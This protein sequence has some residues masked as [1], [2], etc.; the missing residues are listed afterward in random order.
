MVQLSSNG[1]VCWVKTMDKKI[2]QVL[3]VG[4]NNWS[5]KNALVDKP[6][7]WF[8]TPNENVSVYIN[9]LLKDKDK[10]IDFDVILL[11]ELASLRDY[12]MIFK[13]AKPYAVLIDESQIIED[14]HL[15]ELLDKFKAQKI[16]MVD[17]NKVIYD[18]TKYF[19]VGQY[20]DKLNIEHVQISPSFRGKIQYNGHVNLI[21]MG[22]FGSSLTPILSWQYNIP[23]DAEYNHELWL[24]YEASPNVL[25]ALS[26]KMIQQGSSNILKQWTVEGKELSSPLLIENH[27]KSAYYLAISL[28]VQGQGEIKIGNLHNRL[29]RKKFGQFILGGERVVDN[30]HEEIMTYFHPGD[31]KP[32]LNVYFSGYRSAEGFEGYWMMKKLGAPFLLITDPRLEGGAFYLGSN[33]IEQKISTIISQKLKE[34]A[35]THEQLIL[36]GLSMGTFGALYY[37]SILKPSTVIVGKPLVNLGN[38]ALNEKLT[39]PNGFPTSLDLLLSETGGTSSNHAEKLNRRFWDKFNA[40]NF[41]QTMFAIAYMKNDDYDTSAYHD[42]LTNLSDSQAVVISKGISGRHNDDSPAINSW[43]FSQYQRILMDYFQRK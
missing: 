31:M 26:V 1:N 19:F 43:F 30:Q 10:D 9:N 37:A 33:Q 15:S 12:E 4:N 40:A 2:I 14:H 8:F 23:A 18:L 34:L 27:A 6:V 32:P 36:S 11:T 41:N 42:L 29:S 25:M 7:E 13:I 24:E 22:D 38:V 20:G 16:A 21:L 3:Q 39:R 5:K 35:F 17:M 28:K